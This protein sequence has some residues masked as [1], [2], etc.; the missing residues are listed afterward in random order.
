MKFDK[1]TTLY[2]HAIS[3]FQ[4]KGREHTVVIIDPAPLLF[5]LLFCCSFSVSMVRALHYHCQKFS[6]SLAPTYVAIKVLL[7]PIGCGRGPVTLPSAK[8]VSA[9]GG[10][11]VL[12]ALSIKVDKPKIIASGKCVVSGDVSE[13]L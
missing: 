13:N 6:E 4:I 2:P 5:R 11:W 3:D 8:R 1:I 7:H 12:N 10:L 9:S